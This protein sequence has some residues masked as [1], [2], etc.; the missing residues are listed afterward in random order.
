MPVAQYTIIFLIRRQKNHRA[1][2]VRGD[3][4]RYEILF[5]F[6]PV[7]PTPFFR[8]FDSWQQLLWKAA[9]NEDQVR[10][11]TKYER[12]VPGVYF[13]F[14]TSEKNKAYQFS[15]IVF[16]S[17]PICLFPVENT[18]LSRTKVITQVTT[19]FRD[20]YKV[21]ILQFIR[22]TQFSLRHC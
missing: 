5:T 16:L 22:E 8:F 2:V 12:P 20:Y 10:S 9:Q 3:S 6:T 19:K 7:L 18:G 11:P 13:S 4:F 21:N 14:Y 1:F 17:F 15:A